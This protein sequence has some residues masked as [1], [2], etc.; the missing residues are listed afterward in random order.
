MD[1]DFA[2]TPN[3]LGIQE[4][5][6]DERATE[7]LESLSLKREALLA[8]VTKADG[9]KE[10][11]NI[12]KERIEGFKTGAWVEGKNQMDDAKLGQAYRV[13]LLVATELAGILNQIESAAKAVNESKEK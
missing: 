11:E 13:E 9:W 1:D 7:D 12:F 2:V 4:N 8:K 3:A 5:E 6:L 10:V